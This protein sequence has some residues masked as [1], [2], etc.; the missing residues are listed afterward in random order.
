MAA[1]STL[2]QAPEGAHYRVTDRTHEVTGGE[3]AN[4]TRV[5][6]LIMQKVKSAPGIRRPHHRATW[7]KRSGGG[8]IGTG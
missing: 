4:L 1:V 6:L 7:G 5:F 8:V 3:P 2:P